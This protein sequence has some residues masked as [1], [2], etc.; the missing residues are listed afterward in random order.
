MTKLPNDE[1]PLWAGATRPPAGPKQAWH[2]PVP[3][4]EGI[5]RFSPAKRQPAD[6]KAIFP[7]GREQFPSKP[8]SDANDRTPADEG[9]DFL[10][11]LYLRDARREPMLTAAEETEVAWLAS[12]DDEAARERLLLGHLRL[13]VHIAF[14]Y[15]GFGLS[16]CDLINE[17]NIGLMRAAE[18]FKP[19]RGARFPSYAA[20]WI[21]QRMRRALTYQGWAMR[22]PADFCWQQSK[23]R[24]A[25]ARLGSEPD[26][27]PEAED[28]AV[29]CGFSRATVNRLRSSRFPLCLSLQSPVSGDEEGQVLAD[30]LPHEQ[31]PAPDQELARR[32]EREF[33]E[34]LLATLKPREQQVL[35]L[36]FGLDDGHE[37]T[38]EEVGREL[39]YVRQGIHRI[40]S[41][42]LAKL[43]RR[44]QSSV[45]RTCS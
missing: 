33:V 9:D 27:E 4:L 32:D 16:L 11:Q 7:T 19:S 40:E 29:D 10:L 22:L 23:L 21:R 3:T 12:F 14:E 37:R 38:L 26:H 45:G 25:E 1:G 20:L 6:E 43:R 15:R 41:L 39:G 2:C 36:R 17:G 30:I 24:E 18:L 28:L 13:V 34:R 31:T 5:P 35:R 8:T 42:A 44:A